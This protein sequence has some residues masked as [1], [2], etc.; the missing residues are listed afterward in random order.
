MNPYIYTSFS[1]L[2]VVAFLWGIKLMNSPVT[3]VKGNIL[4]ALSMFGAIILTLISNG[5]ITHGFLWLSMTAG[6]IIGYLLAI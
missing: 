6:G 3:A 2:F 5:I 4:S 1:L